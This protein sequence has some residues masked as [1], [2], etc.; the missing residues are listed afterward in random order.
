MI[1]FPKM[2]PGLETRSL[3][4]ETELEKNNSSVISANYILETQKQAV[5]KPS[6]RFRHSQSQGITR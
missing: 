1:V 3:G 5:R 2:F 6:H 4:P